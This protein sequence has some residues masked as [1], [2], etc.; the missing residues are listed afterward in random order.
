MVP[1]EQEDA[2]PIYVTMHEWD[3]CEDLVRASRSFKDFS[4]DYKFGLMTTLREL[5]FARTNFRGQNFWTFRG[6]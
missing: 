1:S 2:R 5:I 4:I 3:A 6:N